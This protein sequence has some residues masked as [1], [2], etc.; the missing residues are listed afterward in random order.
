M[1]KFLLLSFVMVAAA[2]SHAVTVSWVVPTSGDE[3][4]VYGWTNN[5]NEM[6]FVYSTKA[7]DV[8]QA[9]NVA[10]GSSTA[11]TGYTLQ[12]DFTTVK[13]KNVLTVWESNIAPTTNGS[14]SFGDGAYYY[15]VVQSTANDT[16]GNPL[17]AVAG[18]QTPVKATHGTENGDSTVQNGVYANKVG[19]TPDAYEYFDGIGWLG[20][21]WRDAQV[22]EPTVLALLALGVAGVALRRK[23]NLTK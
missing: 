23:K 4:G 14:L 18:T 1:K 16:E 7:L 15:L 2:I 19:G 13:G 9:Y 11:G 10:F 5:I 6:K 12:G 21:T 20:G 17:Y 8:D 3:N 22:P